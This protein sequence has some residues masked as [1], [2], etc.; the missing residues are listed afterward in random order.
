MTLLGIFIIFFY[1]MDKRRNDNINLIKGSH[2]LA[3][4]VVIKKTSY[5]GHNITVKYVVRGQEFIESDGYDLDD[6][7]E[8]GD[9]IILN[10]YQN[11]PSVMITEFNDAFKE[12]N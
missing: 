10:Y 4:G 5:K 8:L 7:V 12:I 1:W 11:D 9:S 3:T 6:K 2:G